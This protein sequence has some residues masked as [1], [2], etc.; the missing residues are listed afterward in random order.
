MDKK[1]ILIIGASGLVG[2]Y[3]YNLFK[4]REDFEIL[5]TYF[6][7]NHNLGLRELNIYDEKATADI[8]HSFSPNIV[9]LPAANPNVDYCET[10]PNETMLINID[11]AK[12]VIQYLSKD[13]LFCKKPEQR[14]TWRKKGAAYKLFHNSV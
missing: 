5:G 6:G 3:L 1:K 11:G 9:I 7:E 8:L 2:S 12:N 13:A 14:R 10:N 4:K